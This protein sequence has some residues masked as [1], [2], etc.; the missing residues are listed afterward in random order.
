[1]VTSA[2]FLLLGLPLQHVF[3]QLVNDS[4]WCLFLSNRGRW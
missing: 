1:L 2:F 4:S 3:V